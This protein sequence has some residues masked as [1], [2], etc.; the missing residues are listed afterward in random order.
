MF[1]DFGA[2]ESTAGADGAIVNQRAAFNDFR[3]VVDGDIRVSKSALG[4]P[5]PNAQFGDL[6]GATGDG[7]LV[8]LA[9]GLRV[10]ERA[11]A[12]GNGFN[13]IELG[14]VGGMG[15]VV[16]E[17]VALAVETSGSFRK[18]RNKGQKTKR[19]E[20]GNASEQPHGDLTG[21]WLEGNVLPG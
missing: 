3:A 4:I 7:I 8:A 13:F 14:Q 9:A 15:G 6:T 19:Q 18:R 21:G 12:I 20:Q 2:G 5:V 11:E 17:A 1:L 16:D 10:I